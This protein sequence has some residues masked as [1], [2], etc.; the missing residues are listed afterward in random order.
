MYLSF[1]VNLHF[2][3]AAFSIL[4]LFS[5][6]GILIVMWCGDVLLQLC[7]FGIQNASYTWFLY[8]PQELEIFGCNSIG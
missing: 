3:I 8:L 2:S 5:S 4:S 1:Y 7:L 6:F